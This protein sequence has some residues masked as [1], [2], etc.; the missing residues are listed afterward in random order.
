MAPGWHLALPGVVPMK[1]FH[2]AITTIG[3]TVMDT[4]LPRFA[5]QVS[6]I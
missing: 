2:H 1:P 4:H 5:Q 6:V 3:R